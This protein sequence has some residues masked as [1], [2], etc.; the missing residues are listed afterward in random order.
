[1]IDAD[2]F[3]HADRHDAVERALDV[4]IVLQVEAGP[5]GQ[6]LF[7]GALVGD[8]VLFLRQRDAGH[9]GAG[10][11]GEI[12]A[13]SAP[14]AAD[15]EH[16]Q[17]SLVAVAAE[18]QLGGEMPLLGELSIV[19]RLLGT[20]EIAAAVLPVGV[21]EQRIEPAVEIVMMRHVVSRAAARIEL[22]QCGG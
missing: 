16:P 18:Q 17:V 2:M 11:L 20:L 10:D 6:A 12:Q 19:E 14:A 13:Q 22:L 3:E 4:A 5:V 7:R 15:V 8:G 1:M 9:I 21:E